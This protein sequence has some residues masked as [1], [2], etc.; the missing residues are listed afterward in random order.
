MAWN[1]TGYDKKNISGRPDKDV[2][3]K[4]ETIRNS[5]AEKI[6]KKLRF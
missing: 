2:V 6:T 5:R 1:F 3:Q 4:W